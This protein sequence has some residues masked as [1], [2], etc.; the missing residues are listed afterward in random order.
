MQKQIA[1]DQE[2]I[3]KS[4]ILL[5][6]SI[7]LCCLVASG[8]I[9][10]YI[11]PRFVVLSELAAAA[12]FLMSAVQLL[13]ANGGCHADDHRSPWM[14]VYLIFIVPLALAVLLPKAVLDAS[15]ASNRGLDFNSG[16]SSAAPAG[17]GALTA[18]YGNGAGPGFPGQQTDNTGIS[19][20]GPIFVTD[21]NFVR[22][23]SAIEQSP[24]DY[25]GREIDMLGFVLK[26]KSLAPQEFGLIRFIIT[27]CTADAMPGGLIL[28]SKDAAGYQDGAWIHTRGVIRVDNYDH[29]LVPVVETTDIVR[30]AEPADPYVYP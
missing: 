24:E 14:G 18:G 27:C 15:V 6:F 11:N 19:I 13:Y 26:D 16:Y 21:G 2:K 25:A 3:I 22:V 30:A 23:V 28:E 10:I 20:S 4:L 9:R 8:Q 5:G 1:C 17:S 29:Q 7:L 12:L